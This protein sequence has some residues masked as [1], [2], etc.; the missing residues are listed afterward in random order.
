[1]RHPNAPPF[2][3]VPPLDVYAQESGNS[4]YF[5]ATEAAEA[6]EED[7]PVFATLADLLKRPELLQP[8]ECVV[9]RLAY[10][11]RLVLLAGPDKSGKSTLASHAAAAV[12]RRSSFLGEPVKTRNGR[13]LLCGLEEA[14]GDAVIRFSELNADPNRVQLVVMAPPD[15]LFQVDKLLTDWP[16]DLVVIDSLAEYARITNSTGVPE[17]G[18]SA[19]WASIVRPLVALARKHDTAVLLL[20]HVRRSDGQYRGSSEIAAAVDALL[21]LSPPGSDE[22][23]AVRKLKG[24]GRWKVEPFSVALRDGVYTIDGGGELS[25]DARIILHV[26]NNRGASKRQLREAVPGRN[27]TIDA[28]VRQ[29]IASGAIVNRGAGDRWALYP[30]S[31][32]PTLEGL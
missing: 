15:L 5:A 8:P 18:D 19:G 12:S 17:D 10:R 14:V 26:E 6:A 16:A 25:L 22:D 31:E 23:P 24:R 7:A 1:M 9:P 13:V 27:A 32:D 2:A 29:L 20:H 21:E 30:P 4:A 3:E 11:G 28:R